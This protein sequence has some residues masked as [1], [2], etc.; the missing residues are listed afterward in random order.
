MR[1]EHENTERDTD[2]PWVFCGAYGVGT[3]LF[4]L[5]VTT[6]I[7]ME[8]GETQMQILNTNGEI[9]F[10]D[11]STS[12]KALVEKAVA[13]KIK[14]RYAD[15]EGANLRGANLQWAYLRG[16]NLQGADLRGANLQ[17]A[18]L[19]QAHL[20]GA[21]LFEAVLT[22]AELQKADLHRAKLPTG[23][24][25][26][27]NIDAAILKAIEEG[28]ILDMSRWHA[29]ETMH[30]RA[31]W[32]IHLAGK[33]GYAL[34]EKLVSSSAAGALIYAASES[35]PVPN[36]DATNEAAMNDIKKRAKKQEATE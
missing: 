24:P 16:A 3:N 9:L 10:E 33:A 23:I 25:A 11:E 15:L 5:D 20:Q 22:E 36:F 6:K 19:A 8:K 17:G 13:K 26:I 27:K 31:G 2:C 14:L 1:L 35:H 29:C 18:M 21:D 12:I 7:K 4:F 34:E 32:A 28:G 30:C